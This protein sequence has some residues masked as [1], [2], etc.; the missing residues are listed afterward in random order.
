MKTD[1]GRTACEQK[2]GI[3]LLQGHTVLLSASL[4]QQPARLLV[5]GASKDFL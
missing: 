2:D 4:S 1:R 5:I 3:K